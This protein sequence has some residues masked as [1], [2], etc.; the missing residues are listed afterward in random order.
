MLRRPATVTAAALTVLA[1]ALAPV[2]S[3]AA[4]PEETC[5]SSMVHLHHQDGGAGLGHAAW[6]LTV[7]NVSAYPCSLS[8]YLRVSELSG[9]T[10]TALSATPTRNGYLG[11]VS[12]PGPLPTIVLVP[13]GS[14]SAMLEGLDALRTGKAC[15]ATWGIAVRLPSVSTLVRM[16]FPVGLCDSVQIHPLVADPSRRTTHLVRDL[17][18][19]NRNLQ[20]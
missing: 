19:R 14:A 7:V 16:R 1:S 4:Q 12:S 18:T 15:P 20:P 2:S 9:R 13:G 5:R 10:T 8:G 11:G 6:I 3:A 17:P